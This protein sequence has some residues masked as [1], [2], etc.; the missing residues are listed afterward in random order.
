MSKVYDGF[1]G[2]EMIRFRHW[3]VVFLLAAA[4][5]PSAQA[6]QPAPASAAAA[7]SQM[8]HSQ[9]AGREMSGM[10]MGKP[11]LP[12]GPL[13][14]VFGGKSAEWTTAALAALPHK[15][16]TLWN[17]HVKANQSF[18][19]VPLIDLLTAL[20]VPAKPHGKDLGLYLVA[21]GADGYKAVYS[22]AEINPDLHDGVALVADS[23]DGK[24]LGDQGPL[25]I[26]LSGEKRP[27]RW[28]RNLEAIH[29]HS[30]E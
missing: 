29:V 3:A 28:V 15:T 10:T 11:V 6:Q 9:A 23:L 7:A 22:V 2:I 8:D 17:E 26:V 27:A 19:G 12:A 30:I 25:Q 20:G 16:V 13:K 18:S 1:G 4:G 21:L 14:I 5:V 24:P